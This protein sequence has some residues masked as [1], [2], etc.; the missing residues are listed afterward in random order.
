MKG[1]H[2]EVQIRNESFIKKNYISDESTA[3]VI[4]IVLTKSSNNLVCSRYLKEKLTKSSLRNTE[5]LKCSKN[6]CATH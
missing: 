6:F 4:F 3:S 1:Q 2:Q 5:N